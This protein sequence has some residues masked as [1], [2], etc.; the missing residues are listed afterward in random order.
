MVKIKKN[1]YR[2]VALQPCVAT[3][4]KWHQL[5]INTLIIASLITHAIYWNVDLLIL[6]PIK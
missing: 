1:K 5:K 6:M 4:F 2:G 3:Y